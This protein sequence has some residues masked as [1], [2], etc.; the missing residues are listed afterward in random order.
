[1]IRYEVLIDSPAPDEELERVRPVVNL[2]RAPQE[3]KATI[4]RA[5]CRW[6]LTWPAFGPR[7]L[8]WNTS[9]PA[10]S[11]APGPL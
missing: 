3:I 4:V 8:R 7:P 6:G 5:L 9:K 10:R 11:C 2:L 1:V